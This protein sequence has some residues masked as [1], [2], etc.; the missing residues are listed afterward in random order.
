[1]NRNDKGRAISRY[2]TATTG[3]PLL[4]FDREQSRVIGPPPFRF[5]VTTDAAGWR[6]FQGIREL[7]D[8]VIRYDKYVGVVEDA[9]VGM[10]LSTFA[11]LL[12]SQY[13]SLQDRVTTYIEGD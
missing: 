6:F 8:F 4:R 11:T 12:T 5:Y 3:I 9:Y 1:V 13:N 2:L 7:D 10:K